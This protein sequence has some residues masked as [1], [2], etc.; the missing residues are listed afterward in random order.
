MLQSEESDSVQTGLGTKI[1]NL[2]TFWTDY[3]DVIAMISELHDQASLLSW[4]SSWHYKEDSNPSS[5]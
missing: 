5:L 2:Q 1:F 4:R 3:K